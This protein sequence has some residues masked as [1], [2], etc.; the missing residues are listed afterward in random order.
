MELLS[1]L[2]VGMGLDAQ[3]LADGE[4][5]EE[6]GKSAAIALT[7]FGRQKS[8]VILDEIEEGTLGLNILRGQRGVS[9]HP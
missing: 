1:K 6:E 7:D 9:T 3:G 5:L 8:L 4:N 2:L